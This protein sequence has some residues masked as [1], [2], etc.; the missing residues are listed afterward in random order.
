MMINLKNTLIFCQGTTAYSLVFS[1]RRLVARLIPQ[2][3]RRKVDPGSTRYLTGMKQ[4]AALPQ[5]T[6]SS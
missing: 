1:H 5:L 4:Q 2:P 6:L 3:W